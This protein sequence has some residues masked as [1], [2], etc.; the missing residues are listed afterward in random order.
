MTRAK[1]DR[2]EALLNDLL[3]ELGAATLT[4]KVEPSGYTIIADNR[5]TQSRSLYVAQLEAG[6]KAAGRRPIPF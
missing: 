2:L 3:A 5:T 6:D 1:V 4:V